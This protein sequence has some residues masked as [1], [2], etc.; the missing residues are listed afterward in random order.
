[1]TIATPSTP[2]RPL[3]SAYLSLVL[4]I[5]LVLGPM[6]V[7]GVYGIGSGGLPVAWRAHVGG[8]GFGMITAWGIL[9]YYR[10]KLGR[11]Q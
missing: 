3:S 1:M 5:A 11:G 7:T 8:F 6:I 4:L 9:T 2:T 10:R